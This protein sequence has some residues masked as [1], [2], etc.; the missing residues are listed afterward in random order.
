MIN[1][2]KISIIALI[3]IGIG[4][5]GCL[6]TF[7][8]VDKGV[9]IHEEKTFDSSKITEVEISSDN[10]YVEVVPTKGAEAKVEVSGKG[11]KDMKKE[12][13]QLLKEMPLL[14]NGEENIKDLLI[15]LL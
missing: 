14:S 6:L 4:V 7:R 13:W 11:P 15:F 12:F 8:A 1:L 10:S 3:L 9:A 2:K 5:A